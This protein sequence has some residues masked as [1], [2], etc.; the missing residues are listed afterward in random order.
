MQHLNDKPLNSGECPCCNTSIVVGDISPAIHIDKCIECIKTRDDSAEKEGSSIN[1]SDIL[2]ITEDDE[3]PQEV[4]DATLHIIRQKM[5][6]SSNNMI[7]FKSGGP[8][9]RIQVF[10]KILPVK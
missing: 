7:Q 9:V 6:R 8:R 3:I 10:F 4:E 5:N 1:L 2:N